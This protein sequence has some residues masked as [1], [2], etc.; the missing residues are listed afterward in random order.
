[1]AFHE[2]PVDVLIVGAGASA[3]VADYAIPEARRA[4]GCPGQE[5]RTVAVMAIPDYLD[6]GLL[7]HV[8]S[9]G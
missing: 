2:D 7:D 6:E 8:V 1:M 3:A 9:A 5:A 4:I